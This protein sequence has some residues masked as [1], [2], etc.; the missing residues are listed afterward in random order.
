MIIDISYIEEVAG[1]D[2]NLFK[3]LMTLLIQEMDST[4]S[5]FIKYKAENDYVG[6]DRVIHTLKNKLSMLKLEDEISL[7]SE[8]RN[9]IQSKILEPE[10]E[11]KI[12]DLLERT[13]QELNKIFP[14]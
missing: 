5:E 7:M 12:K 14:I 2:E 8:V 4:W 11:K 13:L 6:M 3:E 9:R 1:A 10:D